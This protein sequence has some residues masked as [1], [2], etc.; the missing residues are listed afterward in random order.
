MKGFLTAVFLWIISQGCNL[1]SVLLFCQV[2]EPMFPSISQNSTKNTHLKIA[3]DL[4]TGVQM[5]VYHMPP[6][7]QA[8]NFR[9]LSL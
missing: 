1:A 4:Q 8:V 2:N 3:F 7:L 9:K 5:Y 6:S